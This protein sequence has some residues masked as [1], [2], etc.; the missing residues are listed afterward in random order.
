MRHRY[1]LCGNK[2]L[3]RH[4]DIDQETAFLLFQIL[5]FITSALVFLG[6]PAGDALVDGIKKLAKAAVKTP[7][8][9]AK[10]PGKL[11]E[12]WKYIRNTRKRREEKR[13]R[14]AKE[15][16]EARIAGERAEAER[17]AAMKR[18]EEERREEQRKFEE[19]Q[20]K[21][22]AALAAALK[23][24]QRKDQIA[25]YGNL[26]KSEIERRERERQLQGFKR[27][28]SLIGKE[29]ML[30][31]V[32]GELKNIKQRYNRLLS[33]P[34]MIEGQEIAAKLSALKELPLADSMYKDTLET[35]KRARESKK[36]IDRLYKLSLQRYFALA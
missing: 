33:T 34:F 3:K 29:K 32:V 22:N 17:I 21:F 18:A 7:E 4:N 24:K 23:L 9:A 16:E 35:L 27:S 19:T 26:R 13:Q 30:K 6:T 1:S 5:G 2:L 20:R 14:E 36:A 31:N 11:K 15:R 8:A 25:K 10:L 12:L 28:R